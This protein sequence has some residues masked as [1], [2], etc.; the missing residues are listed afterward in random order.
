MKL[1]RSKISAKFRV[2]FRARRAGDAP[3]FAAKKEKRNKTEVLLD[4]ELTLNRGRP[5]HDGCDMRT[6]LGRQVVII[7]QQTTRHITATH[8]LLHDHTFI[9]LTIWMVHGAI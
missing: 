6:I 3:D 1:R 5:L 7:V 9:N 4:F 2:I 8:R